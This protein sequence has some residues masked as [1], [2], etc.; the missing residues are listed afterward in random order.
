MLSITQL[1][2]APHQG[3]CIVWAWEEQRVKVMLCN[4]HGVFL[5]LS[6]GCH[7]QDRFSSCGTALLIR[8]H[9]FPRMKPVLKEQQ[10]VAAS[11]DLGF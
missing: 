7:S 6:Q 9:L 3:Q 1:I 11:G 10:D 4:S 8:G 5:P 2:S